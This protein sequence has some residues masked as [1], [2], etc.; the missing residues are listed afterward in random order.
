MFLQFAKA[1][2]EPTAAPPTVNVGAPL[3]TGSGAQTKTGYVNLAGAMQTPYLY[4]SNDLNYWV[5]P[6]GYSKLNYG[7]FNSLCV[8]SNCRTSWP[9]VDGQFFSSPGNF[10]F[11]VPV[12]VYRIKVIVTGGG[13]SGKFDIDNFGGGAG[14]TC[15]KY[16]NVTPGQTIPVTVGAG[17]IVPY[18]WN[19][20]YLGGDSS[21]GAYCRGNGGGHPSIP[22]YGFM[23]GGASGGDLNLAGGSGTQATY[24][25]STSA[26]RGE[27]MQAGVGGDS[28]WGGGASCGNGCYYGSSGSSGGGGAGAQYRGGPGGDGVVSV[29]W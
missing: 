22:S 14:G 9:T 29:E 5:D 18:Y 19:S 24:N 20:S 7:Y 25:P 1:W 12:N 11:T 3:T 15:I 4:D 27:Y 8:G 21:F 13:A 28:Y 2:T 23:G 6:S 10:S 26:G 16:I 17:G